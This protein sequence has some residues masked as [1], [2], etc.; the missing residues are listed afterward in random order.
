[1]RKTVGV[2]VGYMFQLGNEV[3]AGSSIDNIEAA[4]EHVA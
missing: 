1:M 2:P 3:S 4:N